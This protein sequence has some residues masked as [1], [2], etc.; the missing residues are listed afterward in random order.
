MNK[1]ELDEWRRI[2][3]CMT[4]FN[5]LIMSFILLVLFL[6]FKL[7]SLIRRGL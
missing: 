1:R 4:P 5:R 7:L 3:R 6:R 2:Y